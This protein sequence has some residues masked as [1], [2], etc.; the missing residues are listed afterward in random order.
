MTVSDTSPPVADEYTA[1]DLSGIPGSSLFSQTVTAVEG[2]ELTGAIVYWRLSGNVDGDKLSVALASRGI[3]PERA[4]ALP[5]CSQALTRAMRTVCRERGCFPRRHAGATYAIEQGADDSEGESVPTFDAAWGV[6]LNIAGRL[7]YRHDPDDDTKKKV[8]DEYLAELSS[9]STGDVSSWL[10]REMDVAHALSLRDTGGVYF[11]GR[12][13]LR[14]FTSVV[15]ALHQVSGCR[16]HLVPAMHSSTAVQAFVDALIEEVQA[17]VTTTSNELPELKKRALENR[18]DKIA[19]MT[20]KVGKFEELLGTSLDDLRTQL[21]R[22]DGVT[23]AAAIA[24][25]S[26]DEDDA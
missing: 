6:S 7:E 24:A 22:L 19:R 14:E 8:R 13:S 17:F 23:V 2:G 4:P 18:K 25:I 1:D 11:V 9:L 26:D 5:T 20:E 15:E 10:L 16:V 21:T 3:D 12:D